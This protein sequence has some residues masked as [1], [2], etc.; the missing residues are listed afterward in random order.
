MVIRSWTAFTSPEREAAYVANVRGVVL[1][2]LR[3]TPGY[4]GSKFLSRPVGSEL[5]IVV[6]TYWES[7]DA[8]RALSGGEENEAYMP[9][10]IAATLDRYDHDVALYEVIV[11]D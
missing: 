1:P 7:M 4:V 2:H 9:E 8:A 10:E 6:L 11:D 5:E 3:N